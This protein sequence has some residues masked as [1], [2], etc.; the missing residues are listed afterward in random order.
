MTTPIATV[1]RGEFLRGRIMDI[2]RQLGELQTQVATGRKSVDLSGYGS[3]TRTLLNLSNVKQ[4]TDIYLQTITQT[5]ARM[6]LTQKVLTRIYDLANQMRSSIATVNNP[7]AQADGPSDI[8]LRTLALNAI[9]EI[10]DL[11]NQ[12][13]DGRYLFSGFSAGTVPMIEP[14]DVSQPASPLGQVAALGQVPNFPLDNTTASGDTLYDAIA[15]FFGNSANYYQGDTDPNSRVTVRVDTKLDIAY[16]VRGDNSAI[17]SILQAMYAVASNTLSTSSQGGWNRLV[18]RAAN[19][20]DSGIGLLAQTQG[21]LGQQQIVLKDLV[22]RHN[23]FSTALQN[24]IADIENVDPADAIQRISILQTQ[25]QA[26]YQIISQLRDLSLV[27]YL[28]N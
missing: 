3:Q 2:Q 21:A 19:D 23:T 8:S 16:G 5:Q 7:E 11:L 15:N 6:D 1:T 24:Q 26:S 12:A 25:L 20:L 17:R 4:T 9:R 13:P 18:T 14:G 27:N 22:S 28:T 10:V